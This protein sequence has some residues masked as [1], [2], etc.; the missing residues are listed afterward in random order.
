MTSST[1]SKRRNLSWEH[2]S[3]SLIPTGGIVLAFLV[4]ALIIAI[5]GVSPLEAYKALIVSAFGSLNG[6]AETFVKTT[7]LLLAGLGMAIAYRAGI[8]S[9]GA[10]GQLYMGALGA[11][12]VGLFLGDLAPVIGIPLAITMGFI[13]GAFWGGIAAFLKVKF[14]AN[15]IIVT[16]MLN[17][18]AIQI[19]NYLISGPWRDPE[20]TEPFTAIIAPGTQ[21]PIILPGTRLHGGFLLAVIAAVVLWWVFRKTVFGY[22]IEVL[23]AN[24]KAAEYS[25]I[26]TSRLIFLTMLISGGLCGLA[27]VGEVAGIHHRMIEAIS[28]RYGY[29]AVAIAL[30]GRNRPLGVLVA[31]VLFAVLVVG[32]DGMQ[33]GIGVPVS[34]SLILQGIVLLFVIGGEVIRSR[35]EIAR[36][37]RE[38]G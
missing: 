13:F 2:L 3:S 22:Q 1:L 8:I 33:Q 19:S 11:T 26:P 34:I 23:G 32:A 12:F 14:Q 20:V 29:T 38:S 5:S 9:I 24:R 37:K 28:P 7:P 10:E 17:H 31:A 36:L 27:G 21:L 4:G 6:I 35:I 16:I 30:L 25:G 15:E 18:I